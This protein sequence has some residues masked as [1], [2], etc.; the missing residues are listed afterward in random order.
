M[1][2][3]GGLA[4]GWPSKACE[5][6]ASLAAFLEALQSPKNRVAD[7]ASLDEPAPHH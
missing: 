1:N 7:K 2:A 5:C 4:H 6:P 3:S